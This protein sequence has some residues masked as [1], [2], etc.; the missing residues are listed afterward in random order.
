MKL[1]SIDSS[2]S[3]RKRRVLW[4]WRASSCDTIDLPSRSPQIATRKV[5]FASSL[6]RVCKNIGKSGWR[7]YTLMIC[8]REKRSTIIRAMC[9]RLVIFN[10]IEKVSVRSPFDMSKSHVEISC[11]RSINRNLTLS[12]NC[13]IWSIDWFNFNVCKRDVWVRDRNESKKSDS[14]RL[15]ST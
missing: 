8:N 1:S 4:V 5:N 10:G 3:V 14:T 9:I 15:D 12:L 11:S 2:I 6:M 7:Q 13:W